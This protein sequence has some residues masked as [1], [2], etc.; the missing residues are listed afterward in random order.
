[1]FNAD[2]FVFSEGIIET[3]E[4]GLKFLPYPSLPN[5]GRGKEGKLIPKPNPIF[6]LHF[7]VLG[8]RHIE[9]DQMGTQFFKGMGVRKHLPIPWDRFFH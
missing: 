6:N 3:D 7:F 4:M 8:N 5:K 1:M 2:L 9:T